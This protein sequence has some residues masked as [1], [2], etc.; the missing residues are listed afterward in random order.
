MASQQQGWK[1]IENAR[2][3]FIE[4]ASTLGVVVFRVEFVATFE[5]WDDG[6]GVYVFFKDDA[7]LSDAKHRGFL[8]VSKEAFLTILREEGYPFPTHPMVKFE[9]DSD[10]NV[11][12]NFSG[13]YFYRLQ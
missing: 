9:F 10:E 3:R 1:P 6:I 5:P 7:A 4:W 12:K 11:R 8:D 13:S 2:G